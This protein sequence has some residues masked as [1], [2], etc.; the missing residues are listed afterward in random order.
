MKQKLYSLLVLLGLSATMHAQT[1]QKLV[2]KIAPNATAVKFSFKLDGA[3][4]LKVDF[5]DESKT[6]TGNSTDFSEVAYTFAAPLA[7]ERT[8]TVDA[9]NLFT[10]RG[11]AAASKI[12]GVTEV[13]SDKL[14]NLELAYSDLTTHS[15]L[16]LSKC[17]N[18]VNASLS[19]TN[20]TDIVLPKSEKLSSVIVSPGLTA[21]GSL[22]SINLEDAPNLTTIGITGASI[23]YIDLSKHKLL[24]TL[25]FNFPVKY[26]G[27]RQIKGAKDLHNIK[28]LDLRRNELGF[29]Q[30]PNFE[31]DVP[32]E[33][34]Q[35]GYQTA[36]YLAKDKINGYTLDLSHLQTATGLTPEVKKT[37][38]TFKWKAKKEDKYA[39]IPAENIKEDNGK[40]T[41][42]PTPLG[43]E[44][45]YVYFQMENIGY[46]GI[47]INKNYLASYM[48][49][50]AK[51]KANG[52]TAVSEE[53][54][55]FKITATGIDIKAS[56]KSSIFNINGQ[57]V[58]EGIAPARVSLSKGMYILRTTNG[59][60]KFV[61]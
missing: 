57:K 25:I 29:D 53:P 58:W 10:L 12:V 13:V 38:F 39:V 36:Y 49:T 32:L 52:I 4:E 31:S 14:A 40:Y 20:L 7:E 22:K 9:T 11:P 35:Y 21:T 42:D 59:I 30:I 16:D 46:P 28:R 27:L 26:K 44:T 2:M 5:G 37:K 8:I 41:I 1:E 23:Q 43:V 45:V 56:G 50:L 6:F 19:S 34:F 54:I 48:L 61:M 24:E 3:T 60:T 51:P 33:Q 55:S 47:G 17:P 18:L 15:T